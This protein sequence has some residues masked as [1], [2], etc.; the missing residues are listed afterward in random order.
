MKL[1]F[2]KEDDNISIQLIK[3]TT[4]VDFTYVDMIKELLTDNTIE[5]S[6]FEGDITQEETDRINEML[7]KVQESIVITEP[8]E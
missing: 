4:T 1:I 3:G 8:E 6:I 2:K 7:K 5:E